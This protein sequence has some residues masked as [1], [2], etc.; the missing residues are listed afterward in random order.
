MMKRLFFIVFYSVIC[1]FIVDASTLD[2]LEQALSKTQGIEKA[3]TLNE[4]SWEYASDNSKKALEY[5]QEALK[6]GQKLNHQ[7]TIATSFN[8]I[9]LVYD[10]ENEF[11][12]ALTYYKKALVVNEQLNDQKNISGSLNNIGGIYYYS[13]DYENALTYYLKALTIRET[14]LEKTSSIELEKLV[15]QS[16][17]NIAMIY[18]AQKKYNDA[19]KYYQL[20][21]DVKRKI[22]DE[23]G[24]RTS[25]MNMGAVYLELKEYSH[26]RK[27]SGEALQIAIKNKSKTDVGSNLCLI[28]LTFKSEGETK[29][30]LDYFNQAQNIYDSLQSP[31]ALASIYVNISG[32]Y[33]DLK[34]YNKAILYAEKAL[35]IGEKIQSL[36]VRQEAEKALTTCYNFTK[37]YKKA[38]EH[39]S[40]LILINDSLLNIDNNR[41][42]L[43][44]STKYETQKKRQQIALLD[45]KNNLQKEKLAKEK[46]KILTLSALLGFVITI[47]LIIIFAIRHRKKISEEKHLR[48]IQTH[49]A[50][51]D[52]LQSQLAQK[53]EQNLAIHIN[54][55]E[56]DINSYLVS[57]LTER[58][59]EVLKE[60]ALGKSNQEISD[61]L[62]VSVNTVKTHVLR[63]Y[64]K[65]DVQNRTQAAV[66]ASTLNILD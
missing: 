40:N 65:L 14:L 61:T 54:V 62:F 55:E 31:L 41:A 51:I 7:P 52:L 26:A 64:E 17:N 9:G 2:S 66:K 27:V 35:N 4:L 49:I 30:A 21:L 12:Q 53:V 48:K 5:A 13:G 33:I 1:C 6:I 24:V 11:S 29:L 15:A 23:N 3:A 8:R 16:H 10:L 38:L 50:K 22:N 36:K 42:L 45:A 18:K 43:E 47:A 46:S 37:D 19:L 58:E 20:S 32:V 25:L 60:I 56:Q 34:E 28:G 63:I 39:Q 57:P 59:L 44:L